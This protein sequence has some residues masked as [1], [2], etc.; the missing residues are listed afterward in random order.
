MQLECSK[1][2]YELKHLPLSTFEVNQAQFYPTHVPIEIHVHS[3]G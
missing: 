3:S 1:Q 2:S